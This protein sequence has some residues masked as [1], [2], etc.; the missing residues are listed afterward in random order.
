MYTS[1]EEHLFLTAH[2]LSHCLN[3][4]KYAIYFIYVSVYRDDQYVLCTLL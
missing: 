3:I 4:N 1:R 2:L